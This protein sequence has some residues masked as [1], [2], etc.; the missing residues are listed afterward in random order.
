MLILLPPSEKKKAATGATKFEL[1]S[2]IFAPELSALRAKA[3]AEY[4]SSQTSPAIEIY[5]GVLYQGLGW[6]SLSATQRKRANSRVLI[7]SALFGL[8]KP[9]DQIFQYKLKIESKLW[10]DAIAAV[11]EKF[12]NELIIDCR[13]STYKS[14]WAIN[15]ENTVEVRVFK[16]SGTE[17]SVITH[18]SKKYRG[19]L[20]RHLLMQSIDPTTPA[21]VQR[22]AAEVFECE[23]HPPA[24]GQPW[25][26][27]LL[28]SE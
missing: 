12:T 26:L 7:V 25:A 19:E 2:L 18:M 1:S 27:D 5:D 9:L 4:D 22:M 20:T 13:S 24:N 10:R 21:D 3:T 6:D 16:V 15:P 14:V 23:L 11:S 17:R 28:I 8:V